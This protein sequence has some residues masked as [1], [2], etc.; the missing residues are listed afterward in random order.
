MPPDPDES[1]ADEALQ[2]TPRASKSRRVLIVED[3]LLVAME[4]EAVLQQAGH[5]TVGIAASADEAVRLCAAEQPELAIMDIRLIGVRDGVD[6][7]LEIFARF[8]VRA[9]FVSAHEDDALRAR[10]A[11]AQPLGWLVKPVSPEDLAAAIS[12]L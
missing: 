2:E 11:P 8:G 9:L 10:A 12:K 3:Q 7:A 5:Q 6:A 4:F 1:G